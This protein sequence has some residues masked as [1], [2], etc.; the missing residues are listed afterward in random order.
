MKKYLS[1]CWE[2]LKTDALQRKDEINLSV[3]VIKVEK[4]HQYSIRLNPK[5]RVIMDNQQL[6]PE[7]GKSST[8]I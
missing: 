1:N 2:I 8:T 6:S 7:R 5:Y 3:N 4:R